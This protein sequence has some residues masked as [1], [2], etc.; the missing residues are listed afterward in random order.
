LL[1]GLGSSELHL[2]ELVRQSGLSL[3]TIQQEIQR[4][5]RVG[6]VTARKDGNRICYRANSEHPVYP[7][8]RSLV[9]KTD[10]LVG[11]LQ[12]ALDGRDVN[13]AFIFGSVAL[14]EAQ[15]GSDV[16]LMVLGS[17]GLRRL[18]TL[19]SG[20]AERIGREINPHVMTPV[21]FLERKSRRD[22]FI[23]AVLE[24]PRLFVKGTEHEFK[25]MGR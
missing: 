1:F 23:T 22:H 8:L 16:D 14:G 15:P 11:V 10:G 21:E 13:L 2:R 9:L 4:M 17:I 3:G 6:L 7:D 24:S 18:S 19:L 12:P 25:A 5:I 20:L